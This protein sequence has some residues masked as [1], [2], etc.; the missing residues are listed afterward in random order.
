MILEE[1][2]KHGVIVHASKL[3]EIEAEENKNVK[4]V[5]LQDGTQLDC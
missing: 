1:H 5:K 2:K 4:G 3:A